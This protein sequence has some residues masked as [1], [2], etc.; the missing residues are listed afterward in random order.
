MGYGQKSLLSIDLLW[1]VLRGLCQY[2]RLIM[3]MQG[4]KVEKGGWVGEE[5]VWENGR[6]G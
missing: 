6:R 1:D 4:T 2:V 5:L 3:G